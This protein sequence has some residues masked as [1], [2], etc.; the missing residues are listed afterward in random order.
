VPLHS[1]DAASLFLVA[2]DEKRTS[3]ALPAP[4]YAGRCALSCVPTAEPQPDKRTPATP[5]SVG[6]RAR[7]SR[8]VHVSYMLRLS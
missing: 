2:L 5:A 8:V 4:W 7:A 3:T 6:G 1:I